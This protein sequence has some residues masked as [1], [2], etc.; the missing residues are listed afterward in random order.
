MIS[1]YNGNEQLRLNLDV[2]NAFNKGYEES[3]W[4]KHAY[5]G[6]PRAVQTGFTYAF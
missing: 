3:L 2:H 1:F 5:L 6:E 4:N